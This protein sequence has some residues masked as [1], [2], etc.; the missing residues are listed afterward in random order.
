MS[1]LTTMRIA[2]CWAQAF[3]QDRALIAWAEER[4]G[5][6]FAV[7]IGMDMRRLPA[8]EDA[9]F[10]VLFPESFSGGPQNAVHTH[11]LGL[12]AGIAEKEWA[13]KNGIATMLGLGYLNELCPLLEKAMRMALPK[14]RLQE[15]QLEY[16]ISLY[17][18]ME[19]V[20]TITVAES[21][22]IGRR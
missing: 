13:K 3:V 4:Y 11:V 5:K 22:P 9:P 6:A 20:Y 7:Q 12:V 1:E 2:E 8:E 16:E 19:A 10:L 21:L 17:P 18:L 14:A 15:V